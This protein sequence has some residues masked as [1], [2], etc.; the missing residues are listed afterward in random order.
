MFLYGIPFDSQRLLCS[1]FS[2][3]H[4]KLCQRQKVCL[5]TIELLFYILVVPLLIDVLNTCGCWNTRMN[6]FVFS[7]EA[8][9][10]L[11]AHHSGLYFAFFLKCLKCWRREGCCSLKTASFTSSF[12]FLVLRLNILWWARD[13][14]TLI[15]KKMIWVVNATNIL[16]L[17]T[18]VSRVVRVASHATKCVWPDSDKFRQLVFCHIYDI[19]D[20]IAAF[21]VLAFHLIHANLRRF[22]SW[23]DYSWVV[24]ESAV[25]DLAFRLWVVSCSWWYSGRSD[26]LLGLIDIECCELDLLQLRSCQ[27]RD[28]LVSCLDPCMALKIF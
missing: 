2:A 19:L 26:L 20:L 6:C 13:G 25:H 5:F 7:H 18:C 28:K 12:L 24:S 14:T 17:L 15:M 4:S 10:F 22:I 23:V 16:V 21:L 11:F 3:R 27:A 1:I 9:L 8:F